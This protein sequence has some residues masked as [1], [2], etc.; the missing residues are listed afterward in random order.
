MAGN[1]FIKKGF[2][3]PALATRIPPIEMAD[4]IKEETIN[5]Q[6]VVREG[7]LV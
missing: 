7:Y 2:V 4:T 1:F 3:A 6:A 5:T